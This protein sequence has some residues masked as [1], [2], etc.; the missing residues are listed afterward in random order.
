M[1]NDAI[2]SLLVIF[3]AVSVGLCAYLAF[4]FIIKRRQKPHFL[5]EVQIFLGH[6]RNPL[7]FLMPS[8][9]VVFVKPF[10]RISQDVFT[11]GEFLFNLWII[12]NIGWLSVKV[13]N[14][15]R[16]IILSRYD[17][18]TE[19]NLQARRI[20]T[21]IK[22][23]E[24]I[25]TVVI[26]FFTIIIMM[27]TLPKVRQIGVSL[28]A[29]A[30][31]VGIIM[32]FAAQKTL[33]N[34]IAGIQ[35]A[36]TQPIRLDDVV[37]VENEWGW[38]EEITLTY[39]V[40]RIWDLRRLV[41]PISYFIEKPFQ[42]WTRTSADILGSVFICADYTIPVQEV[43]KELTRILHASPHWDKKVDVL[44]VTNA[45][46]RTV[47]L[48]ALM[49]SKDSPTAWNLRCEVREKLLAFIQTKFPSCLPRMRVDMEQ[50][51]PGS[52]GGKV[53]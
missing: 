30:G 1:M 27:I 11:N 17:I 16:D 3:G 45:T 15:I 5:K 12:A 19:D 6:L 10:L 2:F 35:L 9:C 44:Q 20:Y 36:F 29:S 37:I 33:G 21:Q 51:G 46:D 4:S 18:K 26:V 14:S 52:A 42:N 47:E 23:I 13:V 40:V 50:K 31:M 34:F 41:L 48:R 49:S 38:I 22:I 43:R 28:L 8:L 39:V 53:T 24:H 7:K 25:L 32:G